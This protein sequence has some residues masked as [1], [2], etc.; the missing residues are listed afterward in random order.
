[1]TFYPQLG[2]KQKQGDS[3]V[4]LM[5]GA[6]EDVSDITQNVQE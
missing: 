3:L 6:S 5:S 1:M 2:I 4:N